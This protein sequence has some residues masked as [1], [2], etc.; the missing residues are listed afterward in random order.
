MEPS[1]CWFLP[2]TSAATAPPTVRCRVPGSTG[3]SRPN[4]TRQASSSV[5]VTEALTRTAACS[6]SGSI[7]L[8]VTGFSTTPPAFWAASP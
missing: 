8:A 3:G 6:R 5:K 7:Q 4:G 1:A 2:C